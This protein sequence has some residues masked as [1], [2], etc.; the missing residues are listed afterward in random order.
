MSDGMYDRKNYYWGISD[1]QDVPP[2]GEGGWKFI[3]KIT[4]RSS[5]KF[6][7]TKPK[8]GMVVVSASDL[9][10]EESLNQLIAAI[11]I[12]A[13]SID[14]TPGGK[15]KSKSRRTKRSKKSKGTRGRKYRK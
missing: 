8:S 12:N 14:E 7:W 11:N 5:E 6:F 13:V 3:K 15:R 4:F 2:N 10:D 9:F 1:K